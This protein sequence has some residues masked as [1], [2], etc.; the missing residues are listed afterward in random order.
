MA[1]TAELRVKLTARQTSALDLGTA[2]ADI[3][4]EKVIALTNGVTADKA[5]LIWSDQRTL[6]ASATE[7]LDLAGA[8]ADA[9]G[10]TIAMAK[11]VAIY[12]EAAAG[13]TNNVVIGAATNAI[14]LFGGTNGTFAVK[15]GG[16]FLAA[17]PNGAGLL[18]VGAGSTDVLKVANSSSGTSVTY[19]IVV[20][21]RS[22]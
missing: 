5:D 8:L 9:F 6:A 12:V 7:D 22:A 14:P 19:K 2:S 20:I 1:M 4:A 13:N 10:A 15:P 21:G 3:T 16:V 17:A 11:V 18:S